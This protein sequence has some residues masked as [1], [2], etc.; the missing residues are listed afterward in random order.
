MV[1]WA[2]TKLAIP[3][4]PDGEHNPDLYHTLLSVLSQHSKWLDRRHRQT[5]AWMMV[6]PD[7]LQDRESRGVGAFCGQPSSG[8]LKVRYGAFAAGSTIPVLSLS[9]SMAR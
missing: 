4:G 8:M 5:L 1:G 2:L 7:Q 9:R 3:G 6:G